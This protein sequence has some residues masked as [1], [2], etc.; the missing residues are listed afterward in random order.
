MA[1][2][3]SNQLQ[4]QLAAAY[5]MVK[6]GQAGQAIDKLRR[7]AKKAPTS[8]EV[9]HLSALA[10]KA[11]DDSLTAKRHFLKSLKINNQQPEVH[12][13][14]AN[15]YKAEHSYI[16]AEKHY[17]IALS[18][19]RSY[20]DAK[21]N[22]ALC[23]AAQSKH[24][25][26]IDLFSELLH[27]KQIDVVAL[28]GLADSQREIG[29][30]EDAVLNYQKV[31]GLNPNHVVA[32]HNMGLT[33]HLQGERVNAQEC[34]EK[35]FLLANSDPRIVQSYTS[36]LAETGEAD[37][38]IDVL[39]QS[40]DA[41]PNQVLLHR[42][43]NELLWEN[44]RSK[45]FGTSYERAIIAEPNDEDL[46]SAFITQLFRAGQVE[47]AKTVLDRSLPRFKRS[48][49]LLALKGQIHAELKDYMNSKSALQ[50]SLKIEFT[51]QAAQPLV[52]LAILQQDYELAQETV[53]S[54]IA[55][56]DRCQMSWA[57]QSLLWRLQEDPRYGWLCD[58][59]N[60]IKTYTLETPEGYD[61]L[62]QFLSALEQV[63]DSKHLSEVEPLEQ[64]LRHGTQTAARL[65]HGP[66]P[67]LKALRKSLSSLVERYIADLRDDEKHPLIQ[68]K[69]NK[70]LFSGSWSVKL[71][72]KGFH[73]NHVHPEGWISSSFY[74]R[75]PPSVQSQGDKFEGCIK[76]GESPL[77]L[78]DGEVVER[79]IR[80]E[81]G[82][83]V[84]FPSYFWH[85]TVPFSGEVGEYR[86][87]AP[88]DVV[89]VP[90]DLESVS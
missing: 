59:E 29:L 87:T 1:K 90:L 88:F 25:S 57:L 53:S 15:L 37:K 40:V 75:I 68:R 6:S 63:L 61:S 43:L 17:G 67:E 82:M 34:Y 3:N 30:S 32:W 2:I 65:F 66:E 60:L 4:S 23:Y 41:M 78:G 14:L 74:I 62:E 18:M 72:P 10:Y 26:A 69:S 16:K 35:A 27:S 80:P 71:K 83:V 22:L 36:I 50:D 5:Q 39:I 70:F 64:T 21:K 45:E 8:P 44:E 48:A 79:V 20:S 13:N 86:M 24:S 51:K 56:D 7:L 76:F 11:I 85:G 77:G 38:A 81:P 12:N 19:N 9:W 89:P 31:L 52:K 54:L 46:H 42:R 28:C 47:R 33:H 49:E 73:V 55:K 58:Y 84:L